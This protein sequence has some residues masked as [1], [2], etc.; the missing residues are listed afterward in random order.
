MN[1]QP[2]YSTP[3]VAATT[4][5]AMIF[6]L[7]IAFLGVTPESRPVWFWLGCAVVGI[8][9]VVFLLVPVVRG[10]RH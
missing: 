6:G 2:R 1:E 9:F 10:L 8:L 5:L 7:A 4:V 3:M